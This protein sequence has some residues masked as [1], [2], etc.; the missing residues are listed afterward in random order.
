[1]SCVASTWCF[2]IG[3]RAAFQDSRFLSAWSAPALDSHR[4]G[5][6]AKERHATTLQTYTQAVERMRLHRCWS[7]QQSL[8]INLIESFGNESG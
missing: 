8:S 3:H 6:T 2:G 1:M 7:S 5:S 4:I